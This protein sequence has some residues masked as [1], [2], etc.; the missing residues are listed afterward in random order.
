LFLIY[1][2]SNGLAKN[3]RIRLFIRPLQRNNNEKSKQICLGKKL[4]SYSPNSYIHV[5]VSDLYIPLIG[6][7]IL[8]HRKKGGP[9]EG[10]QYIEYIDRSQTQECGNWDRGRAIPFLGIHIFKFLCS[11][12]RSIAIRRYCRHLVSGS[13][14]RLPQAYIQWWAKLRFS[15][16]DLYPWGEGHGVQGQICDILRPQLAMNCFLPLWPHRFPHFVYIHL[17][18]GGVGGSDIRSMSSIRPI[19][20]CRCPPL[21]LTAYQTGRLIPPPV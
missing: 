4:R 19:C 6:L 12:A 13:F 5:S 21:V 8:L 3:R 1:A 9:N 11:A 17:G 20:K 16:F 14:R 10:I 2:I 18:G 7:P 15:T